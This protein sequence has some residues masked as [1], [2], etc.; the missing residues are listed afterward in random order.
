LI[1]IIGTLSSIGQKIQHEKVAENLKPMKAEKKPSKKMASHQRI[2]K[3]AKT[4]MLLKYCPIEQE[5]EKLEV[6][7]RRKK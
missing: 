2:T 5:A 3:S 1:F 7:H 4:T 6:S